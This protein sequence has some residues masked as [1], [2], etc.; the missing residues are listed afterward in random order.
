MAKKGLIFSVQKGSGATL[1]QAAPWIIGIY[2]FQVKNLNEELVQ[3]IGDYYK[4][5]EPIRDSWT[6]N[7]L[8][9]IP[10]RESVESPLNALPYEQVEELVNAHTKFAVAPCICRTHE[11]KLGRGCDAPLETCLILGD[12]ADF[13]VRTGKGR[14][15]QRSEVQE[16]LVKANNFIF[17]K[18]KF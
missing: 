8:R 12:F 17:M 1:F 7:Q 5:R 13:Y 11:K 16:I 18:A 4:T 2:E 6:L 9:T 14:S 15:I 10:I 3:D